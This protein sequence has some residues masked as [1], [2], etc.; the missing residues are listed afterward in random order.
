VTAREEALD[1]V[2]E[3]ATRARDAARSPFAGL[4]EAPPI[5]H[6]LYERHSRG[7]DEAAATLRERLDALI[8]DARA[9]APK[10]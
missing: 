1:L 6:T 5:V 8:E 3:A 10:D 7:I 2:I 9:A 4:L